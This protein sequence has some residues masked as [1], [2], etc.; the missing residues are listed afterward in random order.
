MLPSTFC[1]RPGHR[2]TNTLD[3]TRSL[4]CR[5]RKLENCQQTPRVSVGHEES[6]IEAVFR[7]A[8]QVVNFAAG[9]VATPADAALC[10]LAFARATTH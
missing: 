10:T 4:C 8:A 2:L 6:K 9:G 3:R 5:S 1:S 7:S